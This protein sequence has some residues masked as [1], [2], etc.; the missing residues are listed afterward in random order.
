[1]V[2]NTFLSIYA[3]RR[4]VFFIF[5]KIERVALFVL[6]VRDFHHH[7]AVLVLIASFYID[8]GPLVIKFHNPFVKFVKMTILPFFF[9][10]C[11][12]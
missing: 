6:V 9:C 1:M 12:M 7:L 2:E 10:S 3:L 8:F 11:D 5:V 4:S